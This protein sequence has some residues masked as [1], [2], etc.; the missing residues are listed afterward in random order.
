MRALSGG[1]SGEMRIEALIAAGKRPR[2]AQAPN[3]PASQ[4]VQQVS[5]YLCVCVYLCVFVCEC[6]THMRGEARK[7]WTEPPG[8]V[9]AT[10]WGCT[11]TL[12][13]GGEK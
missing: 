12:G 1:H 4:K 10:F 8:R 9:K 5:P 7:F 11:P 3:A 2:D 13:G 6:K